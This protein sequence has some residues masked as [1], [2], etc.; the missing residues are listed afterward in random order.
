MTPLDLGAGQCV[1]CVDDKQGNCI[2]TAIVT[3]FAPSP[4]GRLHLGHAYSALRASDFALA[5]AGRFILRIEDIDKDRCREAFVEA[6]LEDLA[7]LGIAWE[8][9]VRRQS[10]HMADYAAALQRL[11]ALGVIYPCFCTRA[12]IAAAAGAPHGIE[13]PI[14]PGTCKALGP[15]DRA[16]GMARNPFAWRLDIEKS[17]QTTGQLAWRDDRRGHITARPSLLGDVVIARKNAGTSYHLA[18]V[19]D[20]A[21]QGI[22]DVV[23]GGDLFAATHIH[24]LLQGLLDLPSPRYHHHA[25]LAGPDGKRLAKRDHAATL[26]AL[27]EAGA[28]PAGIRLILGKM[29]KMPQ[30]G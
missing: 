23:R 12:D 18:V 14:Y 6:I 22:T 13:N 1:S 29:E 10:E 4:T 24:R 16:E 28:T 20:D 9:P 2:I 19:V 27:R 3:R 8:T 7:W 17:C 26:A 11:E 25:L 21:L 15:A 5:A 30:Q